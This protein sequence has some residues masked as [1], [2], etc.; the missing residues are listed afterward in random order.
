[1]LQRLEGLLGRRAAALP[2]THAFYLRPD[3]DVISV[4]DRLSW[5][6]AG[7]VILVIPHDTPVLTERLD[8]L[9]VRRHAAGQRVAVAL[10]TVDPAQRD[11]AREL[12]IPVFFTVEGAA[13][14]RWRRQRPPTPPARDSK[15]PRPAELR[16]GDS[17]AAGY[18]LLGMAAG[19]VLVLIYDLLTFSRL[20]VKLLGKDALMGAGGGVAAG[21]LV[22][23]LTWLLRRYQPRLFRW[24]RWAFMTLAFAF[25]LLAPIVAGYVV[26]PGARLALTPAQVPLSAIARITV[27]VPSPG[28]EGGLEEIDFEGQRIAGRRLSAEVGG[29]AVAGATGVGEVPSSRATGTIV[30][31]NLLAQDYTV[32][33]GTVVRTSAGTPVRF[34]T[35]GDVTV[36]PLGQAAVGIEATEPGPQGNVDVGLVNRVEGAVARA[37][38]VTNPEPTKGGG[39]SQVRAVTQADRE[40]LRRTLLTG[41]RA[42]GY[43]RVLE[44]PDAEGGLREGEYLV[45]GSVR[46]FQVLHETYD[47]FAT[48]EAESVRLEMRVAVTGVA[49]DLGDAYNLARHVLERRLPG[50]HELVDVRY[51][52]GLMGDNVIGDGTLTFFVEVEGLA[53]AR[54]QHDPVKRWLRGTPCEEGMALLEAAWRS[55][56]LP[57]TALPEVEIWPDWATGRFPWLIWRIQVVERAGTQM[58]AGDRQV[59]DLARAE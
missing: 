34:V 49:V 32:A 37:V 23:L 48:E 16:P 57:V 19:M 41:L 31:T 50:G 35:T 39:V 9:R 15:R 24:T 43:E 6:D 2:E 12:K 11:L 28:Q 18:I 21:L 36:P 55:G 59:M 58:N 4:L 25:G 29:E 38:R 10:V 33:G 13:Q 56:A 53:E 54:L 14:G 26:V 44:R 42:Q 22:F 40:A 17:R 47:R 51:R 7:R 1:M 8:L 3:D 30:F 46:V 45:P 5:S 20:D 52:P 27:V